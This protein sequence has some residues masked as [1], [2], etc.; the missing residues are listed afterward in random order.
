MSGLEWREKNLR[1]DP[2]PL[3]TIAMPVYNAGK[4]LRLAVLSIVNQTFED[5]ELLIVDDGSTD[6][7][8]ESIKDIE[9]S[10]IR[11]LWDGENKGLAARLNECIDQASG[12][13]IA[14]MDQDD[15]SYPERLERQI[16]T[17][18]GDNSLDLVAVRA[19]TIDESNAVTGLFPFF[20]T[21]QEI[22]AN[23]WMG[24][25]FPH[26]TW[27]GKIEW[28]RKYRYAMP[29]PFFCEDQELLLR[30]YRDSKFATVNEVLFG[31]RVRA[32][33][34]RQKML[35][36]RRTILSIQLR[37]FGHA[38]QWFYAF[39]AVAAFLG[40]AGNDLVRWAFTHGRKGRHIDFENKLISQWDNVVASLGGDVAP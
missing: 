5:W 34:N 12:K 15:V 36:T 27:M 33:I 7:S 40:K 14:R 31:Y 24:F 2:S 6:F 39:M 28:F 11:I 37:Y 26:P 13:Y 25:Y 8:L 16:E 4:Y 23:P 10:R 17:L 32:K 22:C 30:S 9:D 3:V 29:G 38:R 35:K 18:R 20:L 1:D 21:H 19:I